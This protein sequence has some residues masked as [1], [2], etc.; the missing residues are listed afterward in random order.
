MDRRDFLKAAGLAGL[1]IVSP[2]GVRTARAQEEGPYTGPFFVLVNA[3]GGWDP[4]SFC[5]P[6][7]RANEEESDPMNYYFTGDIGQ[8]GNIRYAPVA[9]NQA[10]FE[11]HYQKI[12]V[13]NGVDT[14]TNG[15]DSGSRHTWSG[16]LAEGYP[17]LGAFLSASVAASKPLAFISNGGFDETQGLVAPTRTGDTGSLTRIAYPNRLDPS[18]ESSE[19]FTPATQARLQAAQRARLD[20]MQER[21]RLPRLKKAM[22]ALYV[23]R[24]GENEIQRLTE[25]MPTDLDRSNNGL[26]RQAQVALAAY[27]A[28]VCAS[29]NLSTGGFDTHG[30]HDNRHFPS[31]QRITEGVD[32]LWEEAARQGI[33]DK[34]VVVV[35]SDFGRT[36]GYNAQNGKDHWSIT[37][38]ML[39]GQ[40]VP[41]NRVV[42]ST[43]DRH[44]P[45]AV[46]PTTLAPS[47]AG[48]RIK[49]G[50]VHRAIRQL[51]GLT[52]SSLDR[53]F[54]IVEE[55]VPLLG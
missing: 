32:F 50:H 20:R 54:P 14:T 10:F 25:F 8:A 34:L 22:G 13:I 42:G 33:A 21:Q 16:R 49:P 18:N 17:A 11:K 9:G 35:G 5:D 29:V 43:T 30:D 48:V 41:G 15:H 24:S 45:I 7:G 2:F 1:G 38:M 3:A 19:L 47:E 4:T 53:L 55:D 12:M 39:M 37:S 31:L 52:G 6:K 40:G 36:P 23:A 51:A 26:I 27:R 28:G 44:R 46:D